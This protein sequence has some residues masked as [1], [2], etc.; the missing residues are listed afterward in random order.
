MFQDSRRLSSSTH[1]AIVE[2]RDFDK[3]TI[4]EEFYKELA[5]K[6]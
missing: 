4:K 3:A 1:E 5:K 2:Y 6:D